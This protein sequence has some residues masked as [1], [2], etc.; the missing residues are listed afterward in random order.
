GDSRAFEALATSCGFDVKWSRRTKP[1]HCFDG[2]H[3]RPFDLSHSRFPEHSRNL[4]SSRN[5]VCFG[6]SI[7]QLPRVGFR[8][9]YG[10]LSKSSNLPPSDDAR[11]A[12]G[13]L[14][15]S[16]YCANALF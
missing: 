13:S 15:G 16:L 1:L 9:L 10:S 12:S 5:Q 8:V 7:I 3:C 11:L 14:L 6:S 4:A 2:T